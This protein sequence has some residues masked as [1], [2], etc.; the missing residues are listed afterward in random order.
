MFTWETYLACKALAAQDSWVPERGFLWFHKDL[1]LLLKTVRELFCTALKQQDIL[2]VN[3]HNLFLREHSKPTI[4]TIVL[5]QGKS[6]RIS[7]LYMK[8][9]GV[10]IAASMFWLAW[11]ICVSLVLYARLGSRFWEPRRVTYPVEA[12]PGQKWQNGCSTAIIPG[13]HIFQ[14]HQICLVENA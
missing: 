6:T 8:G 10:P 14:H 11:F 5:P 9:N 1:L 3:S 12:L 7:A 4:T 13:G 2:M